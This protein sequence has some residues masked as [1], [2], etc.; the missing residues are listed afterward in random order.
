MQN[1]KERVAKVK[2]VFWKELVKK[3]S[4]YSN[5]GWQ[6][7]W[8]KTFWKILLCF[9]KHTRSHTSHDNRQ[10]DYD[11]GI[12]TTAS[13]PFTV[14][15]AINSSGGGTATNKSRPTSTATNL[16]LISSHTNPHY[17]TPLTR[18]SHHS[19]SLP[20]TPSDT[21]MTTTQRD[22][23][24]RYLLESAQSNTSTIE[25][26]LQ[27]EASDKTN[28]LRNREK[29]PFI[30]EAPS[31]ARIKYREPTPFVRR[32]KSS[33]TTN[34]FDL[35]LWRRTVRVQ[36]GIDELYKNIYSVVQDL[37]AGAE[38]LSDGSLFSTQGRPGFSN[39]AV[40]RAFDKLMQE[41]MK[42]TQ[43]ELGGRVRL[44]LITNDITPRVYLQVSHKL[45]LI[46]KPGML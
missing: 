8:A 37:P 34:R 1:Q 41:P 2:S 10:R 29:T 11:T 7:L 5:S 31:F 3:M 23:Y 13:R 24:R 22:R 12:P 16:S 21:T 28:N 44:G 14:L 20:E 19:T 6:N 4:Y 45:N 39:V 17:P 30:T 26:F 33:N 9:R 40:G 18:F 42:V 43:P 15:G 25:Q 27:Q 35:P 36:K 38:E 32:E 46:E